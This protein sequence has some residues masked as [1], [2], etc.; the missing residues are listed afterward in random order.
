M[1]YNVRTIK[2]TA[3]IPAANLDTAYQAMCALNTTHHNQKRGGSWSGGQETGRWFSWMDENYPD[4]CQDAQAILEQLGFETQYADNGD[5]LLVS[6]DS[7]TGQE[8]LFLE[9]IQNLALGRIH[10]LGED[11]NTYTTEFLG[12]TVITPEPVALI[13]HAD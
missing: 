10:W 13:G 5:L 1:G 4:T 6:Y 12:H 7:K 8:D 3:H 9:A 11:G 2:S